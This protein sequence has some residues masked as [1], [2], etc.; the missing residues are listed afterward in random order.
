MELSPRE[1]DFFFLQHGPYIAAGDPSPTGAGS[2]DR[3]LL[4][5]RREC[6]SANSTF[7]LS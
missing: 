3:A 4:T 5:G 7:S 1:R 6:P 2:G